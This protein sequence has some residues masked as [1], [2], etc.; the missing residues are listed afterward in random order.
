MELIRVKD[1]NKK[2]PKKE[3]ENI[4]NLL[5]KIVNKTLGQLERERLFIFPEHIKDS[6][7]ITSDQMILQNIDDYYQTGNIMGFLGLGNERF[8]IESR[9]CDK[10]NDFFLQ[11]LLNKVLN[12][13]NITDMDFGSN[14]DRRLFNLLLLLF[15]RYL[16][17]A[18]RKGLFKTYIRRQ[19]NDGNIRG[20]LDI[21]RHI[22][23][24]TPFTGKIAYSQREFSYDNNLMEL[25]R[26]TIEFIKKK[27]Y[28]SKILANLH[29]EVRIIIAATPEFELYDKQRII[30]TNKKNPVKHAYFG[31]YLELQRLCLLILQHKNHQIG[32]GE[33]QVYGILFDGAWLWEEYINTLIKEAFYHPMNKINREPQHLFSTKTESGKKAPIYPDFIGRNPENRII[34]D[35]KYKPTDNIGNSDYLQLLAYMF[36]FDAKIGYYFY[37]EKGT[38]KDL[39]L[40]L[41]KGSTYEKNVEPRE[42]VTITKHGLKIPQTADNYEAFCAMMRASEEEFVSPFLFNHCQT[43]TPDIEQH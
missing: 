24:N 28:G 19:Y 22:K 2:I 27:S 16:K 4:P 23:Q 42:E 41:N 5:D 13:P 1:N 6:D 8:I 34:G 40:R 7:N 36:R 32:T 17:S 26:H 12:I 37:P 39:C 31:E 33:R 11:Y 43:N 29:D 21:A 35:A 9:F 14:Q 25:V 3:L 15:P 38:P 30:D 18:M 20:T 10:N